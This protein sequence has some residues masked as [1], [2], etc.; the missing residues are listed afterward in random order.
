MDGVR[1]NQKAFTALR[2]VTI[3]TRKRTVHEDESE[4]YVLQSCNYSKKQCSAPLKPEPLHLVY[5]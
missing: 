1:N 5:V 2:R 4:G 3:I